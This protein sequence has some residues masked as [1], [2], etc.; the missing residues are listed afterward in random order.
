MIRSRK[1][2]D[3]AKGQPCAFR[4][5]GICQGST[6][7]TVWAHLNGARYGK[8]AGIKAHDILGGHACFW[9]H[10]YLDTGHG[11]SPQMTNDV[12]LECVLGGVTETL[13]RL[14]ASGVVSV[15]RDKET[16]AHEAPIKPRKP[17]SERTKIAGRSTF[18][19]SAK[20]IPSRPMR[21]KEPTR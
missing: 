1:V 12:F 8:G 15:P 2:L 6:E 16:P 14:I 20:K 3:S 11:T 10:S 9:C 5:P 19:A 7:T 17:P 13:V 21:Q 4:F 18:P